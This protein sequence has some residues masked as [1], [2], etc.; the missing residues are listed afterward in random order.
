M[1]L[2]AHVRTLTAA[3][4]LSAS[5]AYAQTPT[6]VADASLEDLLAVEV[7]SVSKKEESLF[8]APSAIAVLTGE[9]IRRSGATSIPDALR[10]V[11]GLHVAAIDGNKWAVTARGF[12]S[13]YA[14]KL[15]VLVDGRSIYN[16][17]TSGVHWSMEDVPLDEIERIEVIRGPGAAV[18]GANAMNGVINIITKP[19]RLTQGGT[20]SLSAGSVDR[21]TIAARYGGR[22]SDESYFRFFTTYK[23]SGQT[24]GSGGFEAADAAQVGH[25]GLRIDARLS[26]RDSLTASGAFSDGR[27]GQRQ[28][29]LTGV[30]P[31]N[32]LISTRP[33]DA[34]D[35]VGVVR[36]DRRSTPRSDLSLQATFARASRDE[37]NFVRVEN[38]VDVDFQ[39]HLV[40]GRHDLV[41]GV[42]QRLTSDRMNG[43]FAFSVDPAARRVA[44]TN[45]FLHDSITLVPDVLTASVGSKFE[46]NTAV[47]ANVQPNVRLSFSPE[48]RHNLWTAVSH[49]VRTPARLEQ[50]MQFNYA[51]F[52]TPALPVVLRIS[53]NPDL[54]AEHVTA[55]EAGYRVQPSRK[56]QFDATAFYNRYRDLVQLEPYTVIEAAPAPRHL[57]DGRRYSNS[58]RGNTY[59]AEALLRVQAARRWTVEAAVTRFTADIDRDPA[60]VSS[61]EAFNAGSPKLQLRTSSRLTLPGRIEVDANLFRV[62]ELVSAAAPAYTRLD[63]R[64][65][66]GYGPLDFSVVGQNLLDADH[67]EFDRIDGR[68]GSRIPRSATGRLTWTF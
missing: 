12:N 1:T 64:L 52:P 38:I 44:L 21:G 48:R 4:T 68:V 10:L 66:W 62:G 22:F 20:V 57:V 2:R 54:E 7:T 17:L 43:S 15:L 8:R 63:L 42:G 37:T 9:D 67:L 55:F 34:E 40:A 53:G 26:E 11:P 50:G 61:T 28:R 39:H 45:A 51:A 36:W 30:L 60:S 23:N 24:L 41:W 56:I 16:A 5:L 3:L 65:G 6:T 58:E 46:Y 47:G 13:H 31:P 49:A 19:A 14:N 33:T 29:L 35:I 18:W 27:L 25:A 32:L 59:G